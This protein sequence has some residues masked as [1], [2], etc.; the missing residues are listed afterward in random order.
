MKDYNAET[1]D[2]F[3]AGA[4]AEARP[5]L[6]ELRKIVKTTIPEAEEKISWGVPFYRYHGPLVGFSCFKNHVSFGLGL[7]GLRNEDRAILEKQ[8]YATGKKV[9]QIGFSQKVPT[10]AIK[11]I[12]K[13]QAK[14]NEMK[15]TAR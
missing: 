13:M 12:L 8:G 3:I 11:R 9:V 6:R 14:L 15:K 4:P 10:A 5:K 1:V 7:S 2:A